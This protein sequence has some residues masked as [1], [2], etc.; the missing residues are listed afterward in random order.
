VV[1]VARVRVVS[2]ARVRVGLV[3]R[4]RVGLAVLVSVALFVSV[5]AVLFGLGGAI[6]V[7]GAREVGVGCVCRL[8]LAV[9]GWRLAGPGGTESPDEITDRPGL[10]AVAAS[11]LAEGFPQP[12]AASM[13]AATSTAAATARPPFARRARW[14][15]GWRR[16]PARRRAGTAG[17]CRR[18][19]VAR[20]HAK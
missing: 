1:S 7:M 17:E 15:P 18:W 2:V 11:G 14:G 13:V 20:R 10:T 16:D 9:R 19:R 8:G 6:T 5:I 3:A 12:P 4:V